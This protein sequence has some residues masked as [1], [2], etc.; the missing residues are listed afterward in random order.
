ML[1]LIKPRRADAFAENGRVFACNAFEN[2]S[3]A[4]NIISFEQ[5]GPNLALY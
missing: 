1:Y 5:L 3:F 4:N 2:V